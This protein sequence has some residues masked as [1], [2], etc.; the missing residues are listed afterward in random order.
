[1]LNTGSILKPLTALRY[2]GEKPDTIRV[3][4]V[5][6]PAAE[7]YRGFHI[8]DLEKC[9]GCGTCAEICD[10]DAIRMVP[11]EGKKAEPGRTQYRPAIDYGRCCWCALCVDVCTTGSLGM[12]REYIHISPDTDSFFILPREKSIHGAEAPAKGWSA[13]TEVNF[14]DL[15]RQP[16]EELSAEERGASFIEI[17]KGFSAE[18]ARREASRCVSCGLCT[19]VCPANMNIP[20]YIEAI[21]NGD[22]HEA[23]RQMMKTNPLPDVCG[24]ICTHKCETACSIGNRGEPLSIRWLKRYA[25]DAIPGDQYGSLVDQNVVKQSGKKVAIV[26][27]GPSGLSAS[28]YLALMGYAVTLFEAY[29]KVGG[30]MRYGIP[31]YRL[32]DADLDK[33]VNL[34]QSLG[35]AMKT[36]TRVG[37]DVAFE[38]LHKDFDAVLIATGFHEGRST[39]VPGTD[40]PM[41]FQAIDL[42]SR[43]RRGIEFPVEKE[44][45]VI[46]GG[47]VAMDIARSLARLQKK[48]YG[49]VHLTVTSLE[50][51]DIMP[52]D[53]EEIEEAEEEGI[54]FHPGRGPEEIIIQ[55]GKVVGLKTSRCTR[56]FDEQ[57]RF[58][59]AFD[60]ND[61]EIYKGDM[62]VEA[63]GQG[64]NMSYLGDYATQLEYD[65][66]RIKVTPNYQSSLGW[67]FVA[68]DIIKGPDVINGIAVGHKAAIGIDE[69]LAGTPDD[70]IANIDDILKIARE[71]EKQ[72]IRQLE[73]LAGAFAAAASGATASGAPAATTGG[74][75][76]QLAELL[77]A[78]R[79]NLAEL[80]TLLGNDNFRMHLRQELKR[81]QR[82]R[83]Y[84]RYAN[85]RPLPGTPGGGD[86]T[87]RGLA[88]GLAR[89]ER[90]GFELYNDIFYLSGHKEFE[91]IIETLRETQRASAEKAENLERLLR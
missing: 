21:W 1:M 65:G 76:P 6:R 11:M 84:S 10:N 16:M 56:V 4:F 82:A 29:P 50:T 9:I 32:P 59:P 20:E 77:D 78:H 48:K 5:K 19:A 15:K 63:I 22:A 30:M 54:V 14:I 52:A 2:L 57:R 35:V 90:G 74:A 7:R 17:V 60:K 70:H 79:R 88:E 73:G 91:F 67:L 27:G 24:R 51:R 38:D 85:M 69:F 46:G 86:L 80:Q 36:T 71:Y 39:K 68:G 66:R 28:Y 43:I 49:E 12:T 34:I 3:P 72:Q 87:E 31:S 81:E 41:V 61:I 58:N 13:D 42:L 44:M 55:D 40:H 75:A 83:D 8:N 18:E 53:K 37:K 45:V 64:P 23:G 47:N 33:D 89:R 62:V 26:G 25:M